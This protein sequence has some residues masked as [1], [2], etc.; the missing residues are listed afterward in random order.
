M[1]KMQTLKDIIYRKINTYKINI[2]MHIVQIFIKKITF[3]M[4]GEFPCKITYEDFY[5]LGYKFY[6]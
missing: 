5:N 1:Y 2:Y 4:L 6:I 3:F